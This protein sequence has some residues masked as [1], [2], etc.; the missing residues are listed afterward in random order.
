MVRCWRSRDWLKCS[1]E[2]VKENLKD[3]LERA[4][5]APD[6]VSFIRFIKGS[7]EETLDVP[8]NIPERIAFLHLDT[9]FYQSTL[10]ELQVLFPRVVPN[11][12]LRVDDYTTWHGSQK[13]VKEYLGDALMKD[14]LTGIRTMETKRVLL[15]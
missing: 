8:G 10:K 15:G 3:I 13:A 6:K 11:G 2:A 4:A 9:D 7:V 5:D 12:T 1:L 14:P